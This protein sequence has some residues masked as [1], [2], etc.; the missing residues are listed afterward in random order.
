[1]RILLVYLVILVV[2]AVLSVLGIRQV[3]LL[4]IEQRTDA[5]LRQEVLEP[6]LSV[7]GLDP[8]TGRP[9]E[10]LQ[11]VFDVYL[12][13]NVPSVEEAFIAL[14]EGE[15]V[16]ERLRSFPLAEIPD[17]PVAT[18]AEFS[19]RA[20]GPRQIAG[21]FPTEHGTASYRG[22]KV[23]LGAESGA[24]VVAI[25]PAA[26]LG[27]VRA[28]QTYGVAVVAVV[29]LAAGVAA[30]FLTG[31]VLRPVRELTETARTISESDQ[32]GRIRVSRS[33]EAA[34]MAATFNAMLDRLDAA[35][36]DERDFFRAAGHELRA[37]LT[38]ATGHLGL[39]ADG[40]VEQETTLPLVIDELTRMGKIIDDLQSLSGSMAPDYVTMGPID[41]EAFAHETLSKAMALADRDWRRDPTTPGTF[42]ADRFR[43][44]EAALNLA[45]NAIENSDPGD[46]IALGLVIGDEVR[47]SVRD[48]GIGISP[49]D[50]GRVV[51]RFTRGRDA[52]RR[53]RGAGLGLSIVQSI[54]AAH[55]GRIELES[56]LGVGTTV[57]V[58]IPLVVPGGAPAERPEV[59][60]D[61]DR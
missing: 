29:V 52:H 57:T 30:W 50:L 34:E 35:A 56:E 1:V 7:G 46:T 19:R 23:S 28:M 25:L 4:R 41:A 15:V 8:A 40:T 42:V 44:T 5:A 17:E 3:L 14:V 24:F 59:V 60:A 43:L 31:Q 45:D 32:T 20:T 53:Y 37:P 2:A 21:T 33:G 18:W 9:F 16:R 36:A 13:T 11:R 58:A 39:I 55:G 54:A 27:Q 10:S 22:V 48:T 47:L 38:V 12:D 49:E 61:A 26:E 51:E 6:P